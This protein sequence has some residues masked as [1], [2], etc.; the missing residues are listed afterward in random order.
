MTTPEERQLAAL[1][2]GEAELIS[3]DSDALARIRGGVS[4]RQTRRRVL[5][6]ATALGASAA[7]VGVLALTGGTGP[8]SLQP[9]PPA[10]PGPSSA[11]PTPTAEPSPSGPAADPDGSTT[12]QPGTPFFPFT[13]DT[14]AAAW[15]QDYEDGGAAPNKPWA[16]DPAIVVRMLVEQLK[17]PGITVGSYAPSRG[18]SLQVAG[19]EIAVAEVA[20]LGT[21]SR[22]P[23]VVL[24]LTSADGGRPLVIT[25]PSDGAQVTSPLKVTGTI[26]GVDENVRVTLRTATGTVLD[27]QSAPAGSEQP[28]TTTLR[29]D[30]A[31]WTTGVVYGVTRSLKDGTVARVAAIPVR[32]STVNP[33]RPAA[34]KAFVAERDGTIG[35]YSATDGALLKQ[36]SYPPADAVDVSPV[37]AGDVVHWLRLSRDKCSDRRLIRHDLGT[38]VTTT[39]VAD[40]PLWP[41]ALAVSDDGQWLAWAVRPN[42]EAGLGV[43]TTIVRQGPAGIRE[44][45]LAEGYD[46]GTLQLR[47]D[48]ALL[49]EVAGQD[50]GATDLYQPDGRVLH[51]DAR[52]GCVVFNPAF[53]GDEVLAFEVC[54]TQGDLERPART[55]WSLTGERLST[56]PTTLGRISSVATVPVPGG[57]EI[58]VQLLEPSGAIGRLVG[59]TFQ[60]ILEQTACK[61][62]LE[63]RGCITTVDW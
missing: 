15:A 51:L 43:G 25:A 38:K 17:L 26:P 16:T 49:V 31:T 32:R 10:S 35:L 7:L 29:W 61:E 2:R 18:V 41:G 13:S 34:G 46:T 62:T 40:Q 4:R 3:T 44:F 54:N 27:E 12:S 39:L 48:G 36:V 59:T 57:T 19:A 58:L 56:T 37:L 23:W 11:T 45:E 9:Q 21:T 14:Q 47:D 8:T 33:A 22:R 63:A 24:R 50:G 42:C 53:L 60:P 52:E 6:S 30:E 28:W 5:A 1:L 55:T 20:Q